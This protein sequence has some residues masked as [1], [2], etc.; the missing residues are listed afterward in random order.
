VPGLTP[1][2]R[3]AVAVRSDWVHNSNDSFV[4]THPAQR[5]GDIS[6]MVGDDVVRRP[7]T[8]AGLMEVPELVA[9][10]PVTMQ[11]VQAQLFANRNTIAQMVLPDLL[12][13]CGAGAPSADAAEACKVLAAWDRTNNVEARGAH[14]FR[15][16]W[17]TAMAVPGVYR[18]PFDK[19]QPVA[20]PAGLKMDDAAIAGKVWDAL[21]GAVKKVRE[22]GFELDSPLGSVQRPLITEEPIALH[23][24]DEFEGVLNNLGNQYAPGINAKG[25]RID[26]G[27]SYIQTVTFDDRGPVAQGILTYG[28]STDPASP[29]ATDQLRLFS[30]KV[31]PVLPFHAEEVARERVG[32]VLRLT[33]P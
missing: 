23:G 11:A 28:Q 15:E 24:G 5:W 32:E 10:G 19:A 8:R 17:R 6:P 1:I 31:W 9:R 18:V 26:Y 25:L 7:R 21:A 27:S 4:Y 30:R 33:R 29:H 14:L 16:F 12:K 3:M 22:A 20:T 2:E 13:A